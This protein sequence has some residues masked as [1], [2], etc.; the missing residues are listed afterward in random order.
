M[1]KNWEV[2]ATY[3]DGMQIIQHFG[4]YEGGNAP[5]ERARQAALEAWAQAQHSNCICWSVCI[6]KK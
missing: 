1:K 4:Y 5:A 2:S 3:A 6:I